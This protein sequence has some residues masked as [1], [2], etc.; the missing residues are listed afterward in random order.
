MVAL[1]AYL[2][3]SVAAAAPATP[4]H[5]VEKLAST[6]EEASCDASDGGECAVEAD[7]SVAPLPA[8]LDCENPFIQEMIGSCDLPQLTLPS[9]H[10]PALRNG[11]YVRAV[12]H[13]PG[14]DHL[15]LVTASPSADAALPCAPRLA[16]IPELSP[17][18]ALVATATPDAPRFRLD[19][20]PRA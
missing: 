4:T 11:G 18:F 8:I 17:V 14:A 10:L 19:R 3:V 15:T 6:Y 2:L 7:L 1:G 5:A 12:T 9:L 20:P 13:A 16:T